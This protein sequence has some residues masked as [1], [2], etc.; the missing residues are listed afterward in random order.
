MYK[1]SARIS[2]YS[3]RIVNS[4][5]KDD[6]INTQAF[7][8]RLNDESR[9]WCNVSASGIMYFHHGHQKIYIGMDDRGHGL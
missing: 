5:K 7:T 2:M 1:C 8:E 3:P 9:T 6:K 4:V